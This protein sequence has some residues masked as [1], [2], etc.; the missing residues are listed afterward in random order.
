MIVITF[1]ITLSK[2]GTYV[3]NQSLF[4]EGSLSQSTISKLVFK[5]FGQLL[6]MMHHIVIAKLQQYDYYSPQP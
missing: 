6:S 4:T 3:P 2:D 1:S 5:R